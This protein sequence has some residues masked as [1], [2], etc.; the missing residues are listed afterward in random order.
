MSLT[1]SRLTSTN[2]ARVNRWHKGGVHDWSPERWMTATLGELGEA[3]N[4]L[5]KLF[6]IEGGLPNINAADRDLQTRSAAL[7]KIGEE[8]ADTFIYLNLFACSLEIRSD[9]EIIKKF[10]ATSA[11]YGFPERL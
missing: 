5:K 4:A 8:V 3:A 11:K 9:E 1:F 2:I 10:N 6:R 7:E